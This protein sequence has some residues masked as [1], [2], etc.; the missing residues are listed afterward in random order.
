[1]LKRNNGLMLSCKLQTIL[2]H[3]YD[4]FIACSF[5]YNIS[6]FQLL[7][8]ETVASFAV[9]SGSYVEINLSN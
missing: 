6:H 3:C 8:K 4:A 5:S 7:R 2:A 9:K 1:M